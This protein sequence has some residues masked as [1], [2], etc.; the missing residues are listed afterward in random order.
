MAIPRWTRLFALSVMIACVLAPT[1]AISDDDLFI[2]IDLLSSAVVPPPPISAS[3]AATLTF[4]A[5]TDRLSGDVLVAIFPLT[6]SVHIHRGGPGENGVRLA[7]MENPF[8]TFFSIILD[9]EVRD[10]I[11]AGD[12]YLLVTTTNHPDGIVR[13]QFPPQ[14]VSTD[15]LGLGSFKEL[16]Q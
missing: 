6:Y 8:A 16:F 9:S 1:P 15:A 10:V 7:T 11:L 3:G 14:S 5:D 2:P 12:A 13:G 4:E